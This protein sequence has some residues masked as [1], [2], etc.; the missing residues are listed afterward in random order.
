MIVPNRPFI[1]LM[2]HLL[3][4]AFHNREAL[5]SY[6]TDRVMGKKLYRYH[7]QENENYNLFSSRIQEIKKEEEDRRGN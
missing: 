1:S 2:I 5:L 6:N 7:S 3:Q 4:L